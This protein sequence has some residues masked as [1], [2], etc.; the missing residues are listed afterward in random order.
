MTLNDDFSSSEVNF[1]ERFSGLLQIQLKSSS[2]K[3]IEKATWRGGWDCE[4]DNAGRRAPTF[5]KL[6]VEHTFSKLNGATNW[7]RGTER[8]TREEEDGLGRVATM[9]ARICRGPHP[10]KIHTPPSI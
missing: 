2:Q 10:T 5:N 4:Y 1:I 3:M 9:M 8:G 6:I 7:V